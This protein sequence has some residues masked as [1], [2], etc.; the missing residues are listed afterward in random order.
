[1]RTACAK[2]EFTTLG[3]QSCTS[4]VI[5]FDQGGGGYCVPYITYMYMY[6]FTCSQLHQQRIVLFVSVIYQIFK[7]VS[8]VFY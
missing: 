3:S 2:C 5:A 8:T 7:T 1:M 6:L 4:V